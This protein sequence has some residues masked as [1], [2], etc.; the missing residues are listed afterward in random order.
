MEQLVDV[1]RHGRLGTNRSGPA[2]SESPNNGVPP[3]QFVNVTVM[4]STNVL[5]G[6]T[7]QFLRLEVNP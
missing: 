1:R 7:H 2:V 4:V 5:A 3:P 6:A